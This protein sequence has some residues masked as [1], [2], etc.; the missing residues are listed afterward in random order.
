MRGVQPIRASAHYARAIEAVA[1]LLGKLRLDFAFVGAAARSAWLGGI[2]DAGSIDVLAVMGPQQ[3]S[4][5]A[6]MGAN[7]GFRVERDELE[8]TEELDLIPLWFSDP[9][10]ELRV[11]VLVAS[12]ALYG[13]LVAAGVQAEFR[14]RTV[15]VPAAEDLALLLAI[16]GDDAGVSALTELPEFN[17][18]AYNDKL[19]SIGLAEH[20]I[21]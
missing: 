4:Q 7:R 8:R 3:K 6:M 19:M 21:R 18:G 12:N 15:K 11:H 16:S 20:A 13:R 14:D 10:G 2:A 1:E 5:V 9:E 17:R